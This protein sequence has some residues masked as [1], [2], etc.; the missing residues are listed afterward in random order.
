LSHPYPIWVAE[1]LLQQTRVDTVVPYFERFLETFPT[2]HSLAEADEDRLM[3]VWEGL[4]YYSRA[5][6][7]QRAARIVA[8]ERAGRFP[9]SAKE[10]QRLPGVG[11]YSANA[12]ASIAYSECVGVL[13]GN[14][15]RVL[16]RLFDVQ[17]CIDGAE[18]EKTLW[19]MAEELVSPRS[20]GNF[21]QAMMELGAVVCLPKAPRCDACPVRSLCAARSAGRQETLP[22]R[23]QKKPL[24]HYE[25]VVAA[26]EKNGKFL[27]GKRPPG[28]LLGGLWEL[29]GGKV[30]SG[31][32]HREAL[33]RELMEELGVEVRPTEHL[34]SVNHA[35][36]HFRVTLH[37]YRCEWISGRLK[38]HFHTQ[39]RWVPRSRVGRYALPAA[40]RRLIHLL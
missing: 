38:K 17:E 2:V 31:E 29:P 20:P 6:N 30:K 3:K 9:R 4:G 33:V 1:V 11:R 5:R 28:G 34:G 19:A 25:V 10:W 22:L 26:L 15:K 24:P 18:T 13:D 36:S 7:L 23:R 21:N 8:F 35:Y 40:T 27:L 32:T 37:A 14:V 39:V 16:A 12:I